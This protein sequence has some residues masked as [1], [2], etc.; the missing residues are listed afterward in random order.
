MHIERRFSYLP[1]TVLGTGGTAWFP[2]SSGKG[3]FRRGKT[4]LQLEVK[5]AVKARGEGASVP[6]SE[7]FPRGRGRELCFFQAC[8]WILVNVSCNIGF[9]RRIQRFTAYIQR[10]VCLPTGARLNAHPPPT[11]LLE[12]SPSLS[13]R[14]SYSLLPSLFPLPL[15]SSVLFLKSHA[16]VKSDGV[17]LSLTDL[18]L[19]A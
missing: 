2:G 15:R 5:K 7:R 13:L 9:R 12:P 1:S 16:E 6:Q 19:L 8:I 17:C 11:S 4:H 14:V 3:K 10:P 18:V